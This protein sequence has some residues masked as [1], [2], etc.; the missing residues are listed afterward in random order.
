VATFVDFLVPPVIQLLPRVW[1]GFPLPAVPGGVQ[2]RGLELRADGP[3]ADH[4]TLRGDL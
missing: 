4:L 1:S 2:P 3:A